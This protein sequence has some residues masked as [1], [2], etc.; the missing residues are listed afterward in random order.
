MSLFGGYNYLKI[1][2]FQINALS[3]LASIHP[4]QS[5]DHKTSQVWFKPTSALMDETAEGLSLTPTLTTDDLVD[6][7]LSETCDTEEILL[8]P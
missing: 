6:D 3:V 4:L 2:Q 1:T 7:K 8:K 5:I